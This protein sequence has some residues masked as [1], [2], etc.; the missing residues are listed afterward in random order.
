MKTNNIV[1]KIESLKE[2]I[3]LDCKFKVGEIVHHSDHGRTM[4]HKIIAVYLNS[5]HEVRLCVDGYFKISVENAYFNRIEAEIASLSY[6]FDK[7]KRNVIEYKKAISHY[8]N[9]LVIAEQDIEEYLGIQGR[10]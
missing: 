10:P 7:A 4:S 8:Q 6:N 2:Q 9:K 5:N 1:E 3:I